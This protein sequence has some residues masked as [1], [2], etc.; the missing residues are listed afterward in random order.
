M[1]TLF[2]CHSDVGKHQWEARYFGL[3]ITGHNLHV[4]RLADG[5]LLYIDGIADRQRGQF[6][7]VPK[8][9]MFTMPARVKGYEI[10]EFFLVVLKSCVMFFGHVQ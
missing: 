1:E 8:H 3:L 4:P 6:A 10:D 7:K 2:Q 5:P 9:F